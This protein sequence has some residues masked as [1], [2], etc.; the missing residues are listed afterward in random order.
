MLQLSG[1]PYAQPLVQRGGQTSGRHVH[2]VGRGPQQATA[3]Q[4]SAV[5]R[6]A[7]HDVLAGAGRPLNGPLREE[8]EARLGADFSGVRIHDD[9]AARASTAEIGAR[10][11]TSGNN[12]VIGDSGGDKH[13]LA[14]EL[15]HVIQQR[16]GPVAGHDNGAGLKISDPSD[17]FEQEAEANATR[18]LS[19]PAP[20]VQRAVPVA[21]TGT[22]AQPTLQR[23]YEPVEAQNG[24]QPDLTGSRVYI[25]ENAKRILNAYLAVEREESFRHELKLGPAIAEASGLQRKDVKAVTEPMAAAY[26]GEEV[27]ADTSPAV[28]NHLVRILN[29]MEQRVETSRKTKQNTETVR[30]G[31]EFTFTNT[32]LRSLRV[33]NP[34][35]TETEKNKHAKTREYAY[36]LINQWAAKV[37]AA[38]G[39]T[40][41]QVSPVEG[42]KSPKAVRFTYSKDN[43]VVW[44]WTLDVDDACLETQTM[45]STRGDLDNSEVARIIDNDIFGASKSLKLENDVTKNGGSGHISVDVG[46]AFGG[47]VKLFLRTIE[48][49]Q[50]K[51]DVWVKS[52]HENT[53]EGYDQVNSPWLSDLTFKPGRAEGDESPL[54]GLQTLVRILIQEAE[55]G[56]LDIAQ[57]TRRLQEFNNRLDNPAIEA[58]D[59]RRAHILSEMS[60]YQATNVEHAGAPGAAARLELRDVPAQTGRER[61]KK[62]LDYIK[63]MVQNVRTQVAGQ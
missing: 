20:E 63:Q 32:Q 62:D 14:H 52:F 10:A 13:T 24:Q 36:G 18:A 34:D 31:T 23:Y 55:E 60:H 7:V 41:K 59:P 16:Q 37:K 15:S 8:M 42:A 35:E 29:L 26:K 12:V 25:K 11:Y 4:Q 30:F 56:K 61:L 58:N 3:G 53:S 2:G 39:L 45:P 19:A 44:H 6:S 46:T 28:I 22:S 38:N 47:S 21:P 49:L 40:V 9:R 5:Q 48:A 33:P 50:K 57:A 27:D 43:A 54:Q 51:A 1:Y 17:R